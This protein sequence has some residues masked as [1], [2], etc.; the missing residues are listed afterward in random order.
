LFR[1]YFHA[2]LLGSN[3]LNRSVRAEFN[4]IPERPKQERERAWQ[5]VALCLGLALLWAIEDSIN[6]QPS[7]ERWFL[8]V[9]FSYGIA[10]LLYGFFV[11]RLA[12]GLPFFVAFLVVDAFLLTLL[13]V[14]DPTRFAFLNPILLLVIVGAG[15]RYGSRPMYVSWA[16]A[17]LAS[18]LLL[19]SPYWLTNL[20]LSISYLF[21]LVFAPALFGPLIR[22][23]HEV[24]RIEAERARL[25]ALHEVA[26]ARS[27]FLAKVSHELRSPLQGIVSALDLIELRHGHLQADDADLVSRMRRSSL[28]LN[29]QLRDL[30]TLANGE[31]GR[32][33]MHPEPFEATAM[34]EALVDSARELASAKGLDLVAVVPEKPVFVIADGARIDQVLTNLVINSIRYT[35]AGQVRLLLH[36]Y[37]PSLARLRFSVADTGPGISESALPTLFA[38]DRTLGSDERRG[39]GSGLGLAIVRT[40]LELLGGT[41]DVSSRMGKGTT[42]T[43][44]IPAKP[45]AAAESH[46]APEEP[47]GRVLVVD[48]REDVL[49]ALASVIDELGFECDRAGSAAA[50]ADLLTT[51]RYDTVLFDLDMPVKS[52]LELAI[53]TRRGGGANAHARFVGM[54]AGD[55]ASAPGPFDAMLTKPL[56][57]AA[58]RQ[59][60]GGS[61]VPP[62]AS[63]PGLWSEAG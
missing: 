23:V 60:I 61:A 41:I 48:D 49:D 42:F 55:S 31:A 38:P 9:V 54:S 58:L 35:D 29:T 46:E 53:E 17:L 21:L 16:S 19:G 59:A 40:L 43:L 62:R 51:R 18:P 28:L 52:G 1:V 39:K 8:V 11:H 13:L 27:A 7:V 2:Y 45:V 5:R 3:G 20:P 34:V 56:D 15:I 57:H 6:P 26:R 44:E 37:E 32:L 22:R 50:A 30:L 24:R 4:A 14:Q 33:E 10:S 25:A 47:T 36:P 12:A 63:Q